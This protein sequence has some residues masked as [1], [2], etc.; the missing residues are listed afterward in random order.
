MTQVA[1]LSPDISVSFT[2][3]DIEWMAA[4]HP[5]ASRT[6]MH[7][8]SEASSRARSCGLCSASVARY[9]NSIP[10]P[11]LR[12]H[13]PAGTRANVRKGS[14]ALLRSRNLCTRTRVA[15]FSLQLRVRVAHVSAIGRSVGHQRL[16]DPCFIVLQTK[17]AESAESGTNA[18]GES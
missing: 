13:D 3:M 5:A 11:R 18:A 8:T 7:M 16:G 17:R 10:M 12:A 9:K 2:D 14:S 15:M 1:A 6:K 4:D